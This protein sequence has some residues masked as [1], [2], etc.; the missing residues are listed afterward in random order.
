M[1]H[2]VRHPHWRYYS[3]TLQCRQVSAA[4]M[5]IAYQIISST[6]VQSSDELQKLE[7]QRSYRDNSLRHERQGDMPNTHPIPRISRNNASCQ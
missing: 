7:T 2:M 3:S 6:V 1:W 4:H 5:T